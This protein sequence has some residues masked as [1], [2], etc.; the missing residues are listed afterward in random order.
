MFAEMLVANALWHNLWRLQ[1]E[2]P[3]YDPNDEEERSE[4]NNI[5][6]DMV[7]LPGKI[8][9]KNINISSKRSGKSSTVHYDRY[10][11]TN[12]YLFLYFYIYGC[13]FY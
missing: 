5:I 1:A 7:L 4:M 3:K 6:R 9:K 8:K 13:S 10:F 11:K 2:T 12:N